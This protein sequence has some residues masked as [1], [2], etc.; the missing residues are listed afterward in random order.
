MTRLIAAIVML[1]LVVA[2]ASPAVAH[3]QVRNG[4][5]AVVCPMTS[6]HQTATPGIAEPCPCHHGADSSVLPDGVKLAQP[7]RPTSAIRPIEVWHVSVTPAAASAAG[8]PSTID[9]PPCSRD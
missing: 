9:H 4:R 2:T 8:Y 3:E 1:S 6:H 5:A 7:E